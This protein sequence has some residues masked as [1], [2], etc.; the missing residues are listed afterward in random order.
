MRIEGSLISDNWHIT[1]ASR[2][3]ANAR[4]FYYALVLENTMLCGK[5]VVALAAP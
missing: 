5:S 3:A 2:G 4:H 1:N